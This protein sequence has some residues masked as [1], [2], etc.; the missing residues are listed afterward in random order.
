MLTEVQMPCLPGMQKYRGEDALSSGVEERKRFTSWMI[1]KPFHFYHSP[2]GI[3]HQ[4]FRKDNLVP[5]LVE[6]L[7]VG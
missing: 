2:S 6:A 4:T 1:R 3:C 7:F 5:S